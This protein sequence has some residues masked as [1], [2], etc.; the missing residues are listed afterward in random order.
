MSVIKWIADYLTVRPAASR[1]TKTIAT[2][3]SYLQQ[4]KGPA[5]GMRRNLTKPISNM[6]KPWFSALS[7]YL[8]RSYLI[9]ITYN[10]S[11]I[12]LWFQS[13]KL[14]LRLPV[15]SCPPLKRHRG[16]GR[17]LKRHLETLNSRCRPGCDLRQVGR[18][19][20]IWTMGER[21]GTL[22]ERWTMLNPLGKLWKVGI[23]WEMKMRDM[24][25]ERHAVMCTEL[26]RYDRKF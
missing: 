4:L 2:R 12:T 21:W 7:R 15:I 25:D 16:V 13:L 8:G 3:F 6:L 18:G 5:A 24:Q 23:D 11:P 26:H 9:F 17:R 1:V 19:G 20:T 14:C 10:S 22:G